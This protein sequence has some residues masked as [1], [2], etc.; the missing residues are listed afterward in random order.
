MSPL[1]QTKLRQGKIRRQAEINLFHQ[2]LP[3]HR[4]KKQPIK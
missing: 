3:S 1:R 2:R 4:A